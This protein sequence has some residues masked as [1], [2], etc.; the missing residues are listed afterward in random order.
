MREHSRI[1][2]ATGCRVRACVAAAV[3][4]SSIAWGQSIDEALKLTAGD[5]A[6]YDEFGYSI[7]MGDGLV[8]VGARHDDDRGPNSGSV[9]V[10]D[11]Y[12]GD[13]LA[14]LT[15]SDGA[16]DDWLGVSVGIG[17]GFVAVGC[18]LD[19]APFWS[20]AVYLFESG[21]GLE[22]A[23]MFP[24]D[25]DEWDYF[26]W[27]VAIGD[28]LV[29]VGAYGDDDLG[30][31]S[32]SVYLFDEFGTQLRKLLAADG[33]ADDRFGQAVALG[34][35]VIAV[36]AP[37]DDDNGGSSGSAYLFD[38]GSGAQRFKL[39]PADGELS[40]E[41]GCAV[42]ADAGLVVVGAYR[43][44]D[45]GSD[46]GAAY[47]FDA[48][49]GAQVA[50]LLATDGAPDDWFGCSVAIDGGKVVVG[51]RFDGDQGNKFGSA[52]LFDAATGLQLGKFV[53][54]DGGHFDECG[55]SVA[56]ENGRVA[57]G[58]Y[59][60]SDR[61]EWSGSAYV[62]ETCAGDLTHDGSVSTQDF[63]QFLNWWSAGDSRGDWNRDGT[64]NTQDFLAYLNDWSVGCL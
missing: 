29:V 21:S 6:A 2:E 15:A 43:D 12:T 57:A 42:A 37:L 52:Y 32:G 16:M 1:S 36:G 46:A 53:P 20:G 60:D 58:A 9:Y 10:F 26:G 22:M 33:A 61:G 4:V 3:C 25:G 31:T 59:H 44:D 64:V 34:G 63:L 27:S 7:A 49:T 40:D 55:V 41:F 11:A 62:F 39:V 38:A 23:K 54:S 50:K 5:G 35:G 13:Q 56:I 18:P 48:L 47:V 30:A 45:M 28:G 14:K 8:A 51:S 17:D 19:D 24:A